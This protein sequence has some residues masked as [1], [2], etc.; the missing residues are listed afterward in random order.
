ME[1]WMLPCLT[2]KFFGFPCPGCGGQRALMLLFKGE[3][4]DAFLMYPAIFPLLAMVLVFVSHQFFQLKNFS[5]VFTKLAIISVTLILINYI[6]KMIQ[7][8]G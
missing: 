6:F 1:E 2:Q 8:F 3:F 4:T 5:S 7:F